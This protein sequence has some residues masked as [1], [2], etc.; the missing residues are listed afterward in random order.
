[1]MRAD[2]VA[3]ENAA[4]QFEPR[5]GRQVDVDHADVRA[6]GGKDALAALGVGG[7]QQHDLG[8]VGE[9]GTAARSDDGMIIDDQNAHGIG[10]VLKSMIRKSGNRFSEKIML[11]Q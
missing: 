11:K 5:H 6:L 8:F 7:L 3:L 1:M 10:P 4:R 2:R 9:H